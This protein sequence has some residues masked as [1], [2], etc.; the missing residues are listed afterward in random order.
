MMTKNI[1]DT[2]TRA[3]AVGALCSCAVFA[4]NGGSDWFTPTPPPAQAQPQPVQAP[5]PQQAQPQYA[6]PPQ[7]QPAPVQQA[8][9]DQ[10]PPGPSAQPAQP[11]Q[12]AP[13]ADAAMAQ[14]AGKPAQPSIIDAE[15]SMR[16]G[17]E[18]SAKA[19]ASAPY[20][21]FDRRVKPGQGKVLKAK[22]QIAFMRFERITVV[23]TGQKLTFKSGDTVDVLSKP[24]PVPFKGK[25]ARLVARKGRGVVAGYAGNRA[26]VILIDLWSDITGGESIAKSASFTPHYSDRLAAPDTKIQ[27]SVVMRVENS[28]APYLLQYIIIDR[29]A[30][31]GVKLGDFFRVMDRERP[32]ILSEQLLEGQAVNVTA[33]SATLVVHKLHKDH[34]SVGDEA[35]LS[36]RSV[37]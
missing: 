3:M 33:S 17:T 24:K 10:P 26:V 31:D 13:E 15:S 1:I 18:I 7:A 27:A 35:F 20:L 5:P 22:D 12:A 11:A 28:V 16:L 25:S 4:Q 34:L 29:G 14:S 2:L 9:P 37:K 32:Y 23:P 8:L 19:L 30:D 21:I 6:P 36:Y